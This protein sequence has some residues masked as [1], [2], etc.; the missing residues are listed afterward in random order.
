MLHAEGKLES[1]PALE[2]PLDDAV[3][4]VQALEHSDG[5]VGI[6]LEAA[7]LEEPRDGEQTYFIGRILSHNDDSLRFAHLDGEGIWNE[8]SHHIRFQDITCMRF[9]TNYA[10]TFG[11][12]VSGIF[13]AE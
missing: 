6:E 7:E 2:L 4:L 1:W 8:R 13:P 9:R 11:K 3:A 10:Q 12:Y 5:F